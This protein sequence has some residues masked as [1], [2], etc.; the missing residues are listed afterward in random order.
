MSDSGDRDLAYHH[1]EIVR[2]TEALAASRPNSRRAGLL[3]A[4]LKF[5][6]E[7]LTR[8]RNGVPR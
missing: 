5:H 3:R 8:P 7:I 1:A 4:I 2:L 6:E